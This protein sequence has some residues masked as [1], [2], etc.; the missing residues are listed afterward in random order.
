MGSKLAKPENSQPSSSAANNVSSNV[1]NNEGLNENSPYPIPT[2]K[3]YELIDALANELPNII[4]DESRRQVEEYVADCD[5]GSGPMVACFST[6]EYLSLFE[7]KHVEAMHLFENACFRPKSDKSP[8]GVEVDGTKAYLPACYNLGR[9]RMT[10]KGKTKFDRKEAFEYFDRAC[11]GGHDP[12]CFMQGKMLASQPGTLGKGVPYDPYKAVDLFEKVCDN[13]DAVSC[14]SVA[15]MLLRGEK[16][17]PVADN[18]SPLEARG[19]V[20]LKKRKGEMDRKKMETDNRISLKRDPQRAEKLLKKGCEFSHAPSCFNLAVMY[21]Q[22][23]ENIPVD[24]E[25]SEIYKKKTDELVKMFGGFGGGS[26]F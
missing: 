5:N 9:M 3:E 6:A 26:P 1:E 12:S 15:T 4:D 18:V 22:G 20:E 24:K 21:T 8:N 25:K 11:R 13:Q 23:D 2:G 17:N 16:V 10:G 7:R 19:E 14:F